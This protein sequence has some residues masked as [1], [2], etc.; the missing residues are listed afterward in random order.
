MRTSGGDMTPRYMAA[1][2]YTKSLFNC[3]LSDSHVDKLSTNGFC[4]TSS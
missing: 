1:G 3:A 2:S 4:P